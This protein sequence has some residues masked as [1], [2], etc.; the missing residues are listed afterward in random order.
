MSF[1]ESIVSTFKERTRSPFYG[2]FILS[3]LGCNWRILIALFWFD[4]SDL[5]GNNMVDFIYINYISWMNCLVLPLIISVLIYTL[6]VPW[7]DYLLLW[8]TELVRQKKNDRKLEIQKKHVVSGSRY[9]ELLLA[10]DERQKLLTESDEIIAEHEVT[11]RD[12]KSQKGVLESQV[13][14]I[15]RQKNSAEKQLRSYNHRKHFPESYFGRWTLQILR[16]QNW[17]KESI[18]ITSAGQ[19]VFH[20]DPGDDLNW[21]IKY[22][23]LDFSSHQLYLVLYHRSEEFKYFEVRMFSDKRFE[24]RLNDKLLVRFI[25]DEVQG[26]DFKDQERS[27]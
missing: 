27:L 2:A 24:G 11:I 7:I 1:G 17:H 19:I 13:T 10:Y 23:D 5:H 6:I 16:D 4:R 18:E 25:K 15:S 3:W 21:N 26:P 8:Y 20:D 14:E 12:L 9:V 22:M